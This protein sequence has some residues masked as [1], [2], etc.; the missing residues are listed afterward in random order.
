MEADLSSV[1]GSHLNQFELNSLDASGLPSFIELVRKAAGGQLDLSLSGVMGAGLQLFFDE[2][3]LNTGLIRQLLVIVIISALLKCLSDAFKHKSAGELGFYVTYI[4]AVLLAFS[5]FQLAVG[6]LSD[7]TETIAGMMESAVPLIISLMAMSGNVA[8]AAV[9][10]PVLIFAVQMVTRFIS[11]IFIPILLA[12]AVLQIVSQ[13][14][15]GNPLGKMTLLVKKGADLTLK[16]IVFIFALLLT[17]QKISV[18]IAN[19]LALK[20]AKAAAGA[21]PVVGGALSSAMD[22]VL[23]W[24]SAA[25]SG[26]LVALVIVLC[27]AVAV[28]LVKM[29]AIM[30]VCK[31]V[32][33]LAQPVC[34]ERIANCVDQIGSYTAILTGAGAL[35]AVMS[36]YAVVILLSF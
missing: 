5:S 16:A 32:A 14:A 8:G 35:V 18:P 36:I 23:Y 34:D 4:M 25:K 28:P 20:T 33:A 31:L 24:S 15:E 7:M 17:L 30:S 13:L 1:L 3:R 12:S 6:I 9:F 22:T 11:E 19:N 2:L 26:V 21:V 29:V 10:H 27:V